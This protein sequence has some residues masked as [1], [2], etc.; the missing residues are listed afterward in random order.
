MMNIACHPDL[1][2]WTFWNHDNKVEVHCHGFFGIVQ[3]FKLR[4]WIIIHHFGFFSLQVLSKLR[5]QAMFNVLT[6][7]LML[8]HLK[9][10]RQVSC[11]LWWFFFIFAFSKP[12]GQTQLIIMCVFFCNLWNHHDE[13]CVHHH[14][15]FFSWLVLHQLGCLFS[16]IATWVFLRIYLLVPTKRVVFFSSTFASRDWFFSWVLL[17]CGTILGIILIL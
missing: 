9:P 15:S 1:F 13:W 8:Q 12:G 3:A 4:W 14:G 5:R 6:I 17:Y 7:F 10:W 2:F 16:I 11:S